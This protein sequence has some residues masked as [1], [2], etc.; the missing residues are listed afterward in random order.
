MSLFISSTLFFFFFNINTLI[1]KTAAA[2]SIYLLPCQQEFQTLGFYLDVGRYQNCHCNQEKENECYRSKGI[3]G[4]ILFHQ[5][6]ENHFL[7]KCWDGTVLV[8][9][10]KQKHIP[11]L[12][13]RGR[14]LW[15]RF[16]VWEQPGGRW[17]TVV[18]CLCGAHSGVSEADP[19]SIRPL[20]QLCYGTHLTM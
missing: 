6:L 1:D 11:Y 18:Y 4:T 10:F 5:N 20:I 9:S 3:V 19:Q 14:V 16:C 7:F 8:H 2:R 12:L 15:R 13:A 17:V